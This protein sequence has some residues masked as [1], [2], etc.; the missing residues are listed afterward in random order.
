M[1]VNFW[2]HESSD[3]DFNDQE[4]I[5]FISDSGNDGQGGESVF[6]TKSV[7][8]W[9]EVDNIFFIRIW[10]RELWMRPI[11]ICINSEIVE[12]IIFLR[13]KAF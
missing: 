13:T 6:V 12:A 9:Q 5:V 10:C 11:T 3:I 7:F 1:G 2:T 4:D 8:L